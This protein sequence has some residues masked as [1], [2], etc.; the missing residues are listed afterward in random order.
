MRFPALSRLFARFLSGVLAVV[1]LSVPA[2]MARTTEGAAVEAAARGASIGETVAVSDQLVNIAVYDALKSAGAGE[3]KA[4]AAAESVAF[5]EREQLA[6]KADIAETK[7]EIAALR[8]D[9]EMRLG[10]LETRLIWAGSGAM[11]LILTL[12]AGLYAAL[13]GVWRKLAE[14]AEKIPAQPVP[15]AS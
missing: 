5:P 13:I 11:G 3:E 6:T 2:D 9:T 4:R 10:Q 8:A 7:A 15:Q 14:L 1:L 12:I